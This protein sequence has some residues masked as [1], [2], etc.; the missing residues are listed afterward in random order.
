VLRRGAAGRA[1]FV[2]PGGV[3]VPALAAGV[4]LWLL[5]SITRAQALAGVA[6]LVAGGI[7]YAYRR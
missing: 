1:A 2:V 5:T 3:V 6:A 7:L 4:S